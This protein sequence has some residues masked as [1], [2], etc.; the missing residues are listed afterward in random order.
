MPASCH[1]RLLGAFSKP[2]SGASLK[3]SVSL[4]GTLSQPNSLLNVH[5]IS[6]SIL[7]LT[8]ARN[9]GVQLK[10]Q[11]STIGLTRNDK[12]LTLAQPKKSKPNGRSTKRVVEDS[13]DDDIEV[14]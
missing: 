7:Y 1:S 6:L 3:A 13:D 10:L 4:P 9:R 14:A 11:P 2:G 8:M 5:I 12:D